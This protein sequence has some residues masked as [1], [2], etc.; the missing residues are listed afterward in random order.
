MKDIIQ[1]L[2]IGQVLYT[3]KNGVE[4]K[5]LEI[6]SDSS[7]KYSINKEIHSLPIATINVAYEARKNNI[8]IDRLWYN[9]FNL[10]ESTTR[11]CNLCVLRNLLNKVSL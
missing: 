11:P 6:F 1:T 10:K 8:K 5:L 4:Y 9:N 2:Q 3:T 7:L